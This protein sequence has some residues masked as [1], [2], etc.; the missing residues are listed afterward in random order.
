MIKYKHLSPP[1]PVV[2]EVF[3]YSSFLQPNISVYIPFTVLCTSGL[4]LTR[5]KEKRNKMLCTITGTLSQS[6]KFDLLTAN[7]ITLAN[8]EL[9]N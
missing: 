7:K 1:T 9:A 2:D 4:V 5:K 3:P 8:R 6:L